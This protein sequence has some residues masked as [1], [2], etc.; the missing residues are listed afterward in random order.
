MGY[1]IRVFKYA[2]RLWIR[3]LRE[4]KSKMIG[5]ILQTT[6][7]FAVLYYF[8]FLDYF[9]KQIGTTGA[10]IVSIFGAGVLNFIIDLFY[11]P[12]LLDRYQRQDLKYAINTAQDILDSEKNVKT[13]SELYR[14]GKALQLKIST[15]YVEKDEY[16]KWYSKCEKYIEDNFQYSELHKFRISSE[17][18][19][20]G[21]SNPHQ[22]FMNLVQRNL[23]VLNSMIEFGDYRALSSGSL[24]LIVLNAKEPAY[25]YVVDLTSD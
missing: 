18:D 15:Q 22:S 4:G 8:P 3:R 16:L 2:C 5:F 9:N 14:E 13:L 21:A 17:E 19:D 10:L 23:K 6:V 12:V 20:Y 1:Y 7:L 24:Q 25:K 11:A